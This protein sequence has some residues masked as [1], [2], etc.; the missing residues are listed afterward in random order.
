[1]KP[2]L[3]IFTFLLTT[4]TVP[5]PSFAQ[6]DVGEELGVDV[7]SGSGI[8]GIDPIGSPEE[9]QSG[10]GTEVIAPPQASPIVED[11]LPDSDGLPYEEANV[12]EEVTGVFVS[13]TPDL[14]PII[15]ADVTETRDAGNDKKDDKKKERMELVTLT[16][17][18][19]NVFLAA[20]FAFYT[21]LFINEATDLKKRTNS[22]VIRERQP[23]F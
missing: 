21:L 16:F 9:T 19:I 12:Q 18:I 5:Y 7:I 6:D 1:M 10:S 23:T 11:P 13:N 4:Y 15:D 8:S 20:L 22:L 14:K 17:D 2:L 3:V